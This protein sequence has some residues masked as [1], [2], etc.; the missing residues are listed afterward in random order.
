[1]VHSRLRGPAECAHVVARRQ[2]QAFKPLSYNQPIVMGQQVLGPALG[3]L[4]AT[5]ALAVS[6]PQVTPT[7]VEAGDLCW[8]GDVQVMAGGGR[9]RWAQWCQPGTEHPQA[10]S[11][12]FGSHAL[13]CGSHAPNQGTHAA[14]EAYYRHQGGGIQEYSWRARPECVHGSGGHSGGI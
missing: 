4:A 2:L 11:G 9:Y 5:G 13:T 8:A 1:M 10:A 12:G 3:S 7:A 14:V 6:L